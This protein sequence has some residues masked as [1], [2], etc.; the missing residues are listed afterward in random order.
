MVEQPKGQGRPYLVLNGVAPSLTVTLGRPGRVIDHREAPAAGRAA[1]VLAPLVAAVLADAGLD[2]A[3]LAGVA[4]VRGPGSFT[5]IRV[6]LATALGLSLGTG[7]PMAGLDALPLLAAT[8]ARHATGALVV[9]T[10]A[11]AG[12][13]YLQTFLADDGV[14][15]LGPPE[16]LTLDQ[17]AARAA[18]VAA[19]GPVWF[20]GEGSDRYRAV[21]AAAAAAAGFLGP[22]CQAPEPAVLVAAAGAAEYSFQPVTPLYLRPSDAEE[23]LAAIAAGRGLSPSDAE[24]RLR[25]AVEAP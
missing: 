24:A 6:V 20:A 3:G 21:F 5:G 25:R 4:C 18:E 23:N 15:P 10:H 8:A 2:A 22:A 13:V 17:A 12:Q 7:V 1:E 9:V 11:R 19:V 14:A 16:A